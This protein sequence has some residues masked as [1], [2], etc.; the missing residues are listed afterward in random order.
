MEA[1]FETVTV[2]ILN[3]AKICLTL[4]N[5]LEPDCPLIGVSEGFEKMTGYSRAEVIGK[6]CRF[7]N[8]G[9]A[10]SAEDRHRLRVSVL[11][12]RPFVG[13]LQNV[14]KNGEAF[15]S[16]LHMSSIRIGNHMYLLGVQ[17]DVTNCDLDCSNIGHMAE[18][19]SVVDTIFAANVDVWATMQAA[20]YSPSKLGKV[21]P[22]VETQLRPKCERSLY[23]KACSTFVSLEPGL[24]STCLVHKNTF[25]EVYAEE[26]LDCVMQRIRRS[27]S[28]PTMRGFC[29][30]DEAAV[31]NG[32]RAELLPLPMIEPGA[33]DA[34][35][36]PPALESTEA[37]A[38]SVPPQRPSRVEGDLVSRTKKEGMRCADCGRRFSKGCRC[39]AKAVE[40]ESDEDQHCS[41]AADA[42]D[43]VTGTGQAAE[44][45]DA[46]RRSVGSA[47]HPDA[48]TPCSFFC[49]SLIGCNRGEACLFCHMEHPRKIRRRGRKRKGVV[50]GSKVPD[51]QAAGQGEEAEVARTPVGMEPLIH[52]LEMLAP[53]PSV[54]GLLEAG[55]KTKALA[56]SGGG[57]KDRVLKL[58]YSEA[59]VLIAPG[60]RKDVLPFMS[61]ISF[62]LHHLR[63]TVE[64]SL[65]RAL[66]LDTATG[67]ISGV[68]LE[69]PTLEDS[70]HTIVAETS[71][72]LIARA[73]LSFVVVDVQ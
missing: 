26:D 29:A 60:Q 42:E 69:P 25:L 64:P 59:R 45:D 57:S 21:I 37:P 28:E 56:S 49:Y 33:R 51:E 18:L 40:A 44:V 34:P 2:A 5:P 11:T 38:P 4:A 58:E 7:L 20:Q 19:Q 63:F 6:N 12:G 47:G 46:S 32:Q 62:P 17:A 31:P 61:G 15:T 1:F 35:P 14:R 72:G 39:T 43:A 68:I 67:V 53:L 73:T 10:I 52:A 13:T 70:L 3:Q 71:T 8:K 16:L 9:C 23:D 66:S 24:R 50:N 41:E 54:S 55:A 36:T 22:Y 65:P 48:C 27:A 30:A